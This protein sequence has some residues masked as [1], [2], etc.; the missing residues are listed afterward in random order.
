MEL[1]KSNVYATTDFNKA[2]KA[3]KEFNDGEI[4]NDP[5]EPWTAV[6]KPYGDME[7]IVMLYDYYN[8]ELGSLPFTT[9]LVFDQNGSL[10]SCKMN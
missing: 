6:V 10:I 7:W 2:W 4:K 8:N 9:E 5:T 1:I 3:S